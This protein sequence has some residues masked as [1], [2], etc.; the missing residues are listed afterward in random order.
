MCGTG[1]PGRGAATRRRVPGMRPRH[2]AW[3]SS[4]ASNSNCM[5]RQMPSTGCVRVRIT[6]IEAGAAQPRHGV[7]G[8]ADA[9]Q[10]HVGARRDPRRRRADTAEAAPSRSQRELQRGDVG[11]AAGDDDDVAA[12][13]STPLVLGSSLPSRRMRLAQRAPDALE[14]GLDHVMRVLAAHRD[15]QRGAQGFGQR[16]EEMRHELGRQFADAFA[17]E[18]ALRTRSRAGPTGRSRPAPRASSIGSR[19]P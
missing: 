18:A 17:V 16:A 9:G 1:R 5:P 6:S 10:D 12:A 19:K 14:A 4:D 15:V 13:H 7:G 2:C 3:P 8:R 11:A